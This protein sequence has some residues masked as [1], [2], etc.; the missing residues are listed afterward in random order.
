MSQ[1]LY[2]I[3][4]GSLAQEHRLAVLTH[5][6]ANAATIGF[7]ADVPRFEV[8]FP[9][10]PTSLPENPAATER[11]PSPAPLLAGE[12]YV[13]FTGVTADLSP[14]ALRSTGNPLDLALG[15]RGWFSVQTPRGTMYTRKGTFTLDSQ[16]QLVTQEGWPVIGTRGP[17]AIEGKDVTVDPRGTVTVDGQEV[18]QLKIVAPPDADAFQKADSSLFALQPGKAPLESVTDAEVKQGFLELSNVNVIQGMTALIDVMR[19][20]EAYQKVQQTFGETTA[21]GVNDVGRLK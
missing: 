8:T 2:P 14:G 17:I 6:L 19:T 7:K 3:V 16:G 18:D 20:Y 21:R 5:N 12:G 11:I 1:G 9:P 15:G 4:A 13:S 10:P